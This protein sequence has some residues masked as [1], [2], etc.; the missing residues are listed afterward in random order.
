MNKLCDYGCGNTA[1]Y[2]FKNK[3]WCCSDNIIIMKNHILNQN[4]NN[5]QIMF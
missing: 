3:K 1:R 5:L 4:I 2:Q